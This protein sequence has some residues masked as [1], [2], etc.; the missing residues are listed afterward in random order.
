MRLIGFTCSNVANCGVGNQDRS[1]SNEAVIFPGSITIVKDVRNT[2]GD[3]S[4]PKDFNFTTSGL[5]E[6]SFQLDDDGDNTLSNTKVFGNVTDF[7][8]TKTVVEA[9]PGSDFA[10]TALDCTLVS[11]QP[12]PGTANG[13][14]G[15]RT[16]TINLKEGESATCTFTNT[17]QKGT[18]VVKKVVKND[19]GGSKVASDFS[20]QV[21]GG[22]AQAFEADGQ[23]D[24][25]VEAGTYS[26]TEP[27]V[28]GY[29]TTYDNCTNVSVAAG[30]TAT[31]TITNDD[32]SATLIVKKVVK[33]DNG[34]SKVASDFSF[35][36]NGG[37]AQ[38]FEAD[39]Q[40]D[41]TVDA[42]TYSV[43]EP[44]VSGYTTTYDNCSSVGIANGASA[45][46]TITND[47]VAP[48]LTLVKSVTND[49]GG[50]AQPDD[51]HL[52]IGGVATTSGTPKALS[53]N[54]A[55]AINET[56]LTG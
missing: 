15:T 13:V 40:N 47:D 45:T 8:T 51:F 11:Q 52:T 25:T 32:R 18:L 33:N 42:G 5:P 26:V 35:Q 3:S 28:S 17:R 38:A 50:N 48:R 54:Q 12:T 4:D 21:N 22:T 37:A 7:S 36:V 9:S 30:G 10:L 46:C 31:C 34:G 44:A 56:Q 14:V 2:N 27:A 19:N 41:V 55:Y 53:A 23:N 20:F 49:S 1:L 29:S 24:L 6:P 16:A 43:T 39:G